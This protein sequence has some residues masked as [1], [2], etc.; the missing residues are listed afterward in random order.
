MADPPVQA[1]VKD[2]FALM[3]HDRLVELE[4]AVAG[5]QIRTD[6]RLK[7]LGTRTKADKGSVF[8]RIRSNEALDV[9]AWALRTLTSLGKDE[10]RWDLWACQHWSFASG[11]CPFVTEAL[12][13]RSGGDPVSVVT[14]GHVALDGAPEGSRAEAAPVVCHEWFEACIRA[15]SP[16]LYA[17]DPLHKGMVTVNLE[18]QHQL[19]DPVEDKA[20]MLLHGFLANAVEVADVWHP[21]ALNASC[22]SAHFVS[23][24]M[25]H[26]LMLH[27]DGGGGG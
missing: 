13:E 6:P 1:D 8:V 5:L 9:G 7:V 22:A 12:V 19:A 10:T 20:W 18:G 2:A 26:V 25:T 14:V 11:E 3:L 15:A 17:W 16:T 24:F 23:L 4:R 21:R 27:N